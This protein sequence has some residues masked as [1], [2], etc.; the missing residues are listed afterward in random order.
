MNG[1][2]VK[3]IVSII[4]VDK[5]NKIEEFLKVA[6]QDNGYGISKE[7]QK[8]LFKLFGTIKNNKNLNKKGIGLGLAICKRIIQ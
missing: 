8:K 2:L 6:V 4:D 7:D 5:N 3:V 1:G